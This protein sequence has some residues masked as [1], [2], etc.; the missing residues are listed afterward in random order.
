MNLV[1]T[2]DAVRSPFLP[3]SPLESAKLR[4]CR[5]ERWDREK[6][7]DEGDKES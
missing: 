5:D 7:T 2:S 4:V 3:L 6:K 1:Y